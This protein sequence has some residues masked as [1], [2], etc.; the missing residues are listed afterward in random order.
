[1][2]TTVE[3]KV[4]VTFDAN[5]EQLQKTVTNLERTVNGAGQTAQK[6]GGLFG[7]FGDDVKQGIAI[8]FGISTV[9][10]VSGA[11][12]MVKDAMG[13]VVKIG[14]DFEAEMSKVQAITGAT[15]EEIEQLTS[16]AREMGAVTMM[17]AS[18]AAAAMTKLGMAGWRNSEIMAGLPAILDLTVAS[19]QEMAF[20]ADA[21]S[22][23]LTAF[24]YS[25][26]DA[27]MYSDALAYAMT[28]ANVDMTTLTESLKYIAPVASSTGF[29]MQEVVGAVMMLGDAGIK[30]SQAGTSLR[31]VMLN[32][33]GA[34]EK[35]TEKLNELGVAVFDS[36]GK[37][38][39]LSEIMYDLERAT[40]KMTDAQKAQVYNTLVGKT[41]VAGFSTLMEQ[42]TEKLDL[43][44]QGVHNSTGASKEM[45]KVMAD[46]LQGKIET[47]NGGL[48]ELALSMYE[49][50]EPALSAVVEGL[51][52]VVEHIN[53]ANEPVTLFGKSVEGLSD[54]IVASLTPYE[55]LGNAINNNMMALQYMSGIT[56]ATY[57]NMAMN[58]QQWKDQSIADITAK[59][60]EEWSLME[61]HYAGI[62]EMTGLSLEDLKKRYDEHY[63]L[64]IA[65][66]E[67]SYNMIKAIY[68]KAGQEK[69]ALT[70]QE[71][72]DIQNIIKNGNERMISLHT[73]TYEQEKKLL[74][75]YTNGT[76]E[77]T[78]DNLVQVWDEAVKHRNNMI[79]SA[80]KEKD[81]QIKIARRLREV[82]VI[83]DEEYGKM[84]KSAETAHKEMASDADA[85][86]L[87]LKTTLLDQANEL[88]ILYNKKTDEL[89]II[90]DGV[91][92]KLEKEIKTPLSADDKASAVL[93]KVMNKYDKLKGKSR[94]PISIKINTTETTT[95]RTIM[96]SGTNGVSTINTQPTSLTR[97]GLLRDSYSSINYN[98]NL[99]FNDKSDIDYFMRQTARMI[100]R[101]Y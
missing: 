44:T 38:R 91:R 60:S 64:Q 96:S 19:G 50:V 73:E 62:A 18:E 48:E 75:D 88:G 81:E 61:T 15:G 86:F 36:S 101:K 27:T 70:E 31:T 2:S 99:I 97:E 13:A 98:G 67:E 100:D 69:R 7:K 87:Q 37:T 47:L 42:G 35:A 17:S 40:R 63:S 76:L 84:V 58:V 12:G 49:K 5:G 29:S 80:N 1:M 39:S 16:F 3:K 71:M 90:Q 43:Y 56:E 4:V 41:A 78:R 54:T 25:A 55:E 33:T 79:E 21:V 94:S 23:Q 51:T 82:G 8:G 89:S 65:T 22:D 68:D 74:Q 24:G 83:T 10:M 57:T 93:D 45:A 30:G 14:S 6:A 11:I 28:N 52:N 72:L 34:N 32:L 85:T 9:S 26:K 66:T 77:I 53:G 95:K 20:V 46:N 92:V 59:A